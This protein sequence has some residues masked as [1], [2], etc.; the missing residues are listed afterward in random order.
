MDGVE[1]A[2]VV[3]DTVGRSVSLTSAF[4]GEIVGVDDCP[5]S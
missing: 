3:G 5:S 1:L 4:V 2:S